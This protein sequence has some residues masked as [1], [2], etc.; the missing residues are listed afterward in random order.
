MKES[1]DKKVTLLQ[2]YKVILVIYTCVIIG[3]IIYTVYGWITGSQ[4]NNY[5][6]LGIFGATYCATAAEYENLKKKAEKKKEE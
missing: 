1:N 2:V 3:F 4:D 6:L 5:M